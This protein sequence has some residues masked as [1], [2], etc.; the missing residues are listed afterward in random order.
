MKALL[1]KCNSRAAALHTAHHITIAVQ[2]EPPLITRSRRTAQFSYGWGFHAFWESYLLFNKHTLL[3]AIV[4]IQHIMTNLDVFQRVK[5]VKQ[6]AIQ[7]FRSRTWHINDSA[8]HQLV[9]KIT[10]WYGPCNR[11]FRCCWHTNSLGQAPHLQIPVKVIRKHSNNVVSPQAPSQSIYIMLSTS[12]NTL[13]SC[14][15]IM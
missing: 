10:E 14:T 11:F 7:T 8:I 5:S 6:W 1:F 9:L 3:D 15:K 2:L 13:S 12:G 4:K